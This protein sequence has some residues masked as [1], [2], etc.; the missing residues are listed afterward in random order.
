[1]K[2]RLTPDDIDHIIN[3]GGQDELSK[4]A[5]DLRQTFEVAPS[6]VVRATHLK[7]MST[8]FEQA[9]AALGPSPA[10]PRSLWLAR[11]GTRVAVASVVVLAASGAL[12]ATGNLPTRAQDAISDAAE[13][14]GF[15]FPHSQDADH[16]PH[17][18]ADGEP[19]TERAEANRTRAKAF[20]DAKRA[21][22]D[23]RHQAA[24]EQPEA[25]PEDVCGPKPHPSDFRPE[26][27][28]GTEPTDPE[29]TRTPNPA[30]HVPGEGNGNSE[31][32]DEVDPAD[33]DNGRPDDP[34]GGTPKDDAGA[35]NQD[36]PRPNED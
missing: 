13:L 19:G 29:D 20:V 35:G 5:D 31:D 10:R 28:A 14:V 36:K 26:P 11:T 21:W 17:P 8:A 6:P 7:A 22:N 27:A 34:G 30:G 23:C 16:P 12:A 2:K 25:D 1:M 3:N 9:G 24:I 18:N 15:D 4:F 32:P 33:V